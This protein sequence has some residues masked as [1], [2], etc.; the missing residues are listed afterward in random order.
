LGRNYI[1]F[2]KIKDIFPFE[3]LLY[4]IS[5]ENLCQ[6]YFCL[7]L[8]LRSA[9]IELSITLYVDQEPLNELEIPYKLK[10]FANKSNKKEMGIEIDHN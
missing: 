5:N 3:F 6:G 1:W 9:L 7:K 4:Q 10:I 8:E 2:C